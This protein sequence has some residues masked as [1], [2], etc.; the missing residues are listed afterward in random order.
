MAKAG[1]NNA[2]NSKLKMY[3]WVSLILQ[4]LVFKIIT[5]VE[6]RGLQLL[7][8]LLP[9]LIFIVLL[10]VISYRNDFINPDTSKSTLSKILFFWIVFPSCMGIIIFLIKAG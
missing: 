8:I 7:I 1:D 3:M 9:S 2:A 5:P 6:L 10:N 4:I